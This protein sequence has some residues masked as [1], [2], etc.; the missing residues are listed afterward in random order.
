M[1]VIWP[2]EEGWG[3]WHA[4]FS[5]VAS[6]SGRTLTLAQPIKSPPPVD[7]PEDSLP[8][9]NN[10]VPGNAFYLTGALS[11]LDAPGEY[12]YDERAKKLYF[13]APDGGN[14]NRLNLSLKTT[15][16]YALNVSSFTTIDGFIIYGGGIY[17]AG[18]NN[19]I[20]NCVIRYAD[21]FYVNGE[22]DFH[23]NRQA[24]GFTVFGV[25]NI[26]RRC[27]IGPTSAAGL[28]TSGAGNVI[29]D[30]I[31]HNSSYAGTKFAALHAYISQGLEVSNNTIYNSGHWQIQFD[32]L[33]V[34][35]SIPFS[36][37]VVKNNHLKNAM[38]LCSDGGAF[39]TYDTDGAGSEVF[40]NFV[41]S[42]NNPYQGAKK[43]LA[44]GLYPDNFARNYIIRN[45]IILGGSD[46]FVANLPS[47]GIQIFNNT[48]IGSD[49]GFSMGS[50]YNISSAK[51]FMLKDN[52]FV[53]IKSIDYTYQGM[54][55]GKYVWDTGNFDENGSFPIF[56][57][58]RDGIVISGNAR[59]TVDSQYRP[60]GDTPNIGAIP[61][62]GSMF[63]YG[64]TWKLGE[65]PA[66]PPEAPNV[67]AASSW[68]RDYIN[69]AFGNGIIPTS[70]Q[71][72]YRNNI[73]R[74]EFCALA[75]ELIETVT[76]R[77][78][79]ER[80]VFADDRGDINIRKI[81]G[82]GIVTGTGNN[83]AGERLFAPND[84]IQRQQ[85]ALIL[86]RVADHLKKPLPNQAPAFSDNNRMENWAR[87]PIGQMQAT[88]IMTG[89]GGN[90]DPR[91]TYT[92]EQSIITM[93]RMWN[94]VKG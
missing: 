92:R 89:S 27:E 38:V 14:P 49:V 47:E 34:G 52:L 30:N 74:A 88:G 60:T 73:T 72:N 62:G 91:G 77:P 50:Q 53:D 67:S 33:H 2:G 15:E 70:L 94:W 78:I 31:I 5:R 9:F 8:N 21:H 4:S 39:Y 46:G 48:V 13:Y 58:A 43:K 18:R 84:P 80:Q 87:A 10:P 51:G 45:N 24:N 85:A 83:A 6:V 25:D 1:V 57:A 12:Y 41:E 76:G 44:Q 90:F 26:V 19:I 64:A 69:T 37:S 75:V 79:T 29:T 16:R 63:E 71:N 56:H 40:N 7:G 35:T 17:A 11:L 20:Q 28:V 22:H 93:V 86:T 81:G 32:G 55:N 82:L 23:N 3:A 65:V 36:G 68:A 61:R 54:D 42:N 59:G 66:P